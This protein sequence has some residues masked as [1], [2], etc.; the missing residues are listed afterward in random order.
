MAKILG[1]LVLLTI[2]FF[3]LVVKAQSPSTLVENQLAE[4]NLDAS[5]SAWKITR[6]H[7]SATSGIIHIY[8]QQA[9]EGV[10][11]RGTESSLHFSRAGDLLRDNNKFSANISSI[12]TR[13]PSQANDPLMAIHSAM[14]HLGIS[15]MGKFKALADHDRGD[16]VRFYEN[17]A[18]SEEEIAAKLLYGLDE[19]NQYRLIWEVSILQLDYLRYMFVDVDAITGEIINS[20][21]VLQ[22][23]SFSNDTKYEKQL[24]YNANLVDR[25]NNSSKNPSATICEVCYEV[26]ASPF[27]N[28]FSGERTIAI[29]PADPE[30]SPFGWHDIDGVPGSESFKT[31]GNNT[32]V[33]ERGDNYGYQPYGGERL[34]FTGYSFDPVFTIEN[35]SED[36]AL[37]NVFYWNNLVH[38]V[39]YHYG[40]DESSNNFQ[41]FNYH[42]SNR[43]NDEME[44][45]VQ[46]RIGCNAFYVDGL[47]ASERPI[48][49]LG[50]CDD[51]DGAYDNI[52]IVHEYTHAIVSQLLGGAGHGGCL[53][54]DEQMTEGWADWMGLM[55]TIDP[56]DVGADRRPIGNFFFGQGENGRGIRQ[57]PYSTDF[58]VNP[59]TYNAIATAS[60]PHGVGSVWAEML[61]EMTWD[62]IDAYGY[63]EDLTNFTGDVNQDAG[64]IMAL[65]VV[66]EGL[67]LMICGPGFIDARD[68]ILT[69][70]RE[71]YG[72]ENDC[73]IFNAFARR[74][75]GLNADQGLP[76]STEDGT[77]DF[78]VYP[79]IAQ[80]KELD[81]VCWSRSIVEG[82]SGGLPYGG[83]Y[84]GTGIIDEGNGT[85]FSVDTS[86]TGFGDIEVHYSI[87]ETFCI[88]ES[89]ATSLLTI[90]LDETPPNIECPGE[91]EV[92]VPVGE[93]FLLPDF[94][95]QAIVTDNCQGDIQLN[96]EP[97]PFTQLFVGD[98]LVTIEA[99]DEA[100][101]FQSC[102]FVFRVLEFGN[103]SLV[104]ETSVL[105]LPV[106]ARNEITIYNP[107]GKRI[108]SVF[109]HD[110]GGRMIKELSLDTIEVEYAVPLTDLPV[111]NYFFTIISSG[112]TIIRRMI[113]M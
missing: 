33:E 75:L 26:F 53:G 66:T 28:P 42:A 14:D 70:N 44:T 3:T 71:I 93:G 84:S 13:R 8:Y 95:T 81:P 103:P 86:I 20:R 55:L 74:G 41:K 108:K 111:G 72:W 64:N 99:T 91:V 9:I 62:L 1:I 79:E 107:T 56:D 63:D 39:T 38:D 85:T 48:T 22:R 24:D 36:A 25:P 112:D 98:H 83:V 57:Y 61:W 51:K 18:V 27:E 46:T 87:E 29:D 78:T 89:T 47:G 16:H 32:R 110:I 5:A 4:H 37:I 97:E 100:G 80:F 113:K 2:S 76:T 101:L 60:I 90:D 34:D 68:A 50:Y 105:L 109:I 59:H 31:Q 6:D 43:S 92:E 30:A 58:T 73:V 10:L 15:S 7:Q 102:Q 35:Q 52:I 88:I 82:L 96:Q 67:K 40:F 69:A 11:L 54:N 19:N 65:A 12:K 17:V 104:F 106:P 94:K 23:C 21:D 49:I 77:E 45:R